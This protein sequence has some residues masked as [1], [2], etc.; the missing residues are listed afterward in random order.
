M[1]GSFCTNSMGR[2]IRRVPPNWQH[3]QET[4]FNPFKGKEETSYHPLYN[5]SA[6]VEWKEWN[7]EYAQWLTSEHARVR[8]E[9]GEEYYPASQPYA[10][11]CR[12][13]GT[14]PNPEYYRPDWAP[15]EMT[16][17]QVYE[18]VSEGTPVTPPFATQAEL[19][20]YLV[21][22]GDFWDQNRRREGRSSMNCDPWPREQAEKFVMGG[23]S[24]PSLVSIG[25]NIMSGVEALV[26]LDP[27]PT[28]ARA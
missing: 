25:G 13:H 5:R 24:T 17:Y 2:E 16:W 12:W 9:Y 11:F 14:P 20:D 27:T 19:I 23:H 4:K 18:T 28:R 26:V 6:E 15:E 21:A 10:S 3:P 8:A 22:N 1:R 7:A